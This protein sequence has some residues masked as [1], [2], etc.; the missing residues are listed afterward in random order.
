MPY[1]QAIG[2]AVPEH[3]YPQSELLDFMLDT[4]QP[5]PK[6]AAQLEKIYQRSGI[7]TRHSVLPD[8]G[9]G[10]QGAL[11]ADGREASLSERMQVYQ[12]TILDLARQAVQDLQAPLTQ[13]THLIAVSCTGLA[14]PGLDLELIRDLELPLTTQ[15][16]GVY[17]LGCYAAMH[18][19][20]QAQAI[21]KADPQAQ[22]LIVCAELCT[23]H[24]QLKLDWDHL[25]S[26]MLF[27][28][29]AAAVLVGALPTG[30]ALEL[31]AFHSEIALAGWDAMAWH[32]SE[33]GFL[34]RLRPEVP[35]LLQGAAAGLVAR[36][37][38]KAGI[39][40]E[41][42]QNWCLHPGGRKIVDVFREALDLPA[43]ALA[44]SYQTLQNYGNMSSPTVLFVL[45][46]LI[47]S[48]P[49]Q[50]IFAAA[51][52]PGLSLESAVLVPGLV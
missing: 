16:T 46:E 3:A 22:V 45:K 42:I 6:T 27:A 31:R 51:F 23:L 41:A 1:I 5:D 29:G 25:S 15:R 14:A 26:G 34:M 47:K 44:A 20:K 39:S 52:G 21:C 43:E 36:A 19:L 40:V 49:K 18:A 8:F 13:V 38:A 35:T 28:D 48:N 12:Q 50:A 7:A 24:F 2:T 33:T 11:F 32:P 30:P 37:A 10:Q 17:F 9:Q 4:L